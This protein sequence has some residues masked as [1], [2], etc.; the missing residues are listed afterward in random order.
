MGPCFLKWNNHSFSER[1]RIMKKSLYFLCILFTLLFTVDFAGAEGMTSNNPSSSAST[2][3]DN[4][5]IQKLCEQGN[6]KKIAYKMY[7]LDSPYLLQANQKACLDKCSQEFDSCMSGA[8]DSGD[9]KFRCEDRLRM[10]ALGCNN[11]WYPK[12]KF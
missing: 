10:C 1:K 7:D 3:I 6:F 2:S 4:P 12:L 9:A 8:S 11:E 5:V